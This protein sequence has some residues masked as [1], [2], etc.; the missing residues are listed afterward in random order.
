MEIHIPVVKCVEWYLKYS[1]FE[2]EMW[3]RDVIQ[4]A[5]VYSVQFYTCYNL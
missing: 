5:I 4:I 2:L 1:L 3:H